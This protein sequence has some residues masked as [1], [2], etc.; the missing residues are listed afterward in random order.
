MKKPRT[1]YD[2]PAIEIKKEKIACGCM[3]TL[4]ATN[5]GEEAA[6]WR[7]CPLAWE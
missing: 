7:K 1:C 4:T 2:C 6:M 3:R 5:K